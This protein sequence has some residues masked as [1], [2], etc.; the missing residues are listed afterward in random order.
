MKFL[1]STFCIYHLL[2][3][4]FSYSFYVHFLDLN[5]CFSTLHI[6]CFCIVLCIV[7]PFTYSCLFPI[8]VQVYRPLSPDENPIAVNK[9]HINNVLVIG[10]WIQ[11]DALQYLIVILNTLNVMLAIVQVY[12]DTSNHPQFS[13]LINLHSHTHAHIHTIWTLFTLHQYCCCAD[14]CT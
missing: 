8:F 10:A 1:R 14:R 12:A 2:P 11:C 7:S 4:C 5:F 6:L 3:L 13:L 9:Y